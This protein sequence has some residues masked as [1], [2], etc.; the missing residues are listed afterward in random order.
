MAKKKKINS[1]KLIKMVESGKH[2]SEIIKEF[3]FNSA[4]QFK[5]YYLTALI[6][7][8][9]AA[10]IKSGRVVT[11]PNP[12]KE[13]FVSKRGS[14]VLPK[15]LVDDMRFSEGVKFMVRKTKTGISLKKLI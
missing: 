12:T 8:G 5:N 9:K 15:G 11:K 7:S 10:E 4:A 2:Q 3:K 6:D 1:A 13:V 14:I